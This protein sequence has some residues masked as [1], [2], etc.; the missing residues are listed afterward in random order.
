LAIGAVSAADPSCGIYEKCGN[1]CTKSVTDK[2]KDGACTD[3][4]GAPT[5][6]GPYTNACGGNTYCSS[7]EF[8]GK[9][10]N[11]CKGNN[12]QNRQAEDCSNSVK[13]GVCEPNGTGAGCPPTFKCELKPG[14]VKFSCTAGNAANDLSVGFATFGLMAAA[15]LR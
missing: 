10:S 6:C 13:D 12:C 3:M 4:F 9:K 14:S 11:T 8:C 2:C 7:M 15:V 1:G 5:P